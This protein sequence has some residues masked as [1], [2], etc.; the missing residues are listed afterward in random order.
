MPLADSSQMQSAT[1]KTPSE[2]APMSL[3]DFVKEA[4]K[5]VGMGDQQPNA[6]DLKNELDA[7]KIGAEQIKVDVQGDKAVLTGAAPSN[8][9]LERAVVAMGNVVGIS[10]VEANVR[11]PTTEGSTKASTMYTV[12]NGDTLSN[13]AEHV[14]GKGKSGQFKTILAANQPMLSDPDKIYPG[15]VLRIPPTGMKMAS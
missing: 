6:Q 13:I 9:I 15:Q 2:E 5:K 4:G 8:D 7:H 11:V 14:Y 3:I 10:K 1:P 12:K